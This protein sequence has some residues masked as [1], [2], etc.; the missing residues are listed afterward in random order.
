MY[1]VASALQILDKDRRK[2]NCQN[3]FPN[4]EKIERNFDSIN[5]QTK[6]KKSRQKMTQSQ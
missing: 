4:G 3:L 6:K 1:R 2:Q 5:L